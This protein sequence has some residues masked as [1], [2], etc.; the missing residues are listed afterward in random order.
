MQIMNTTRRWGAVAKTLHWVIVVLIITQFVLANM[1]DHLPL[2]M[3][4]LAMLA[5]HKSVGITILGLAILRLGWRLGNRNSPPLPADLRPWQRWLAHVSHHGLYFLL[6]AL[7]LTGWAMSSAKNYPVSWF[8]IGGGLPNFVQPDESMFE[9]MKTT[10]HVLAA[11][12]FGIAVLHMLAA[13]QHHFM[14]KDT[15]LRRMLPFA[16]VPLFLLPLICL[17]QGHAALAASPAPAPNTLWAAD[18]AASSLEFQFMQAGAKTT[19]RFSR[20][21]ASIDFDPANLPKARFDVA[22]EVASN[23]TQDKDRDNTLRS[24]ELFDTGKFPRATYAATLFVKQGTA[25]VA[26]GKLTLHGVTRA[27]P[28]TFT[29]VPG[30]EA[31][32]A[33]ATLKGS[34]AIKRLAFGVGTGEW[35]STEWVTDDVQINFSLLLRPRA[36]SPAVPTTPAPA[37]R[38]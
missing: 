1:A 32:K 7:P 10:H 18:P 12:L 37:Q 30:T 36:A 15:V 34:A 17:L 20:F 4:K 38:K 6:F 2:G 22:I 33:V 13:F 3:A 29:F 11:T 35:N 5:R 31:G 21:V 23:D 14:R 16:R 9:A 27:V 28:V 25:Y 26:Q 19:G 24:P 8:G